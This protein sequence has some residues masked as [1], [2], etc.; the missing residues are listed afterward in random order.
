LIINAQKVNRITIIGTVIDKETKETIENV[1]VFLNNTTIGTTTGEDGKFIIHNVP[2]GT[3]NII[4][5]YLGYEVESKNFDSYKS[6]TFE[7]NISLRP[8]PINLNQVNVTA[9]VPEEWKDDLEIF[10]RI[11]IGE[12]KNSKQTKILNPEVLNFV[13]EEGSGKL[14]AYSDSVLRIENKALGYMLYVVLDSVVYTP[15]TKVI[16]KLYP[17]FKELTP[18]SKEEK[19]EWDNNRQKTY[20]DSPRHFY[21]ALVHKQL[22]Q[23][24]YSIRTGTG[25]PVSY[26]DLEISCD[27][28]STIYEF[29]YTGKLEVMSYLNKKNILTFYYPSVTIDK[30]GNLLSYFYSV[31]IN[32]YWAN[33]RIADILPRDYIYKGN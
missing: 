11:F 15:H 10:T 18:G 1:N 14:K 29:Q 26:D 16:Y 23:D 27:K 13:S 17:R 2:Y 5:S 25:I 22:S 20:L 28:D 6:Y 31:E 19:D 21:Y 3:Y 8:K 24:Y 4:F 12:T 32:G 33:Q 7:F 9:E 30:N